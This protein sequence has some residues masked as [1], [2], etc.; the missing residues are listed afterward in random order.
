ME[1][2]HVNIIID[3]D[4]IIEELYRVLSLIETDNR[5]ARNAIMEIVNIVRSAPLNTSKS[6][7]P[8]TKGR[9]G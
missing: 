8:R 4:M 1:E 6:N 5:N 9:H 3:R 2:S 7:Y